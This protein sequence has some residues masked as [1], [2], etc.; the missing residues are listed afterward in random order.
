MANGERYVDVTSQAVQSTTIKATTRLACVRRRLITRGG[1]L[2]EAHEA[3]TFTCLAEGLLAAAAEI[4]AE[5]LKDARPAGVLRHDPHPKDRRF[6][7]SNA[8]AAPTPA[9]RARDA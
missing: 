3:L 7:P 9:G 8:L 4:D 1:L 2:G 5:L 6:S